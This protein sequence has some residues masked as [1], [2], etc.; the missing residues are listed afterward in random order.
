LSCI[1][2]RLLQIIIKRISS[3]A[4]FVKGEMHT[5]TKVQNMVDCILC[6][7]PHRPLVRFQ[8]QCRSPCCILS[9]SRLILRCLLKS[10]NHQSIYRKQV[11]TTHA[12]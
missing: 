11:S 2:S 7:T 12:K 10:T 1:L 6:R 3:P 4:I 8:T 5:S 9:C